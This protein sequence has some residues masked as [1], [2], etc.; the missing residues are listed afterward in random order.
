MFM[1]GSQI[2]GW[3]DISMP[4]RE[5]ESEEMEGGMDD[6][7][8]VKDNLLILLYCIDKVKTRSKWS[9]QSGVGYG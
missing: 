9:P 3:G 7:G 2:R 1:D 6:N 4:V 5:G 8:K